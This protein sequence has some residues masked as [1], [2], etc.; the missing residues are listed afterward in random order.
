LKYGPLCASARLLF[1]A[2]RFAATLAAFSVGFFTRFLAP[3]VPQ[4]ALAA[5]DELL[6]PFLR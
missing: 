4:T 1:F 2:P 6:K 5:F 3:H